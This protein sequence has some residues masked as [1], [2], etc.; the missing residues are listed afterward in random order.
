MII[1]ITDF[2]RDGMKMGI[3]RKRVHIK[4]EF[5]PITVAYIDTEQ[6]SVHTKM[7]I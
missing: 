4:N 1:E 2:S 3:A 6:I 5:R 7:V